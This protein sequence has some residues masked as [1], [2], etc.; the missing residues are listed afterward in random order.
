MT[1]SAVVLAGAA[2]LLLPG[3]SSTRDKAAEV[4]QEG[5]KAFEAK[6]L[7]LT[8]SNAD[9]RVGRPALV[10]DQNGTAVVV[11]LENRTKAT[12]GSVP[13]GVVVQDAAGE[14]IWRNDAAGLQ[15]SLAS[16]GVL[17]AGQSLTWVND[18]VLPPVGTPAK[19]E[20]Q[21]GQA[22]E[23][24]PQVP[25]L[26]AGPPTLEGDPVDG[27]AARGEV[28][29]DSDQ[30]LKD[31]VVTGVGRR[32]SRVVAAGRAVI[33]RLKPRSKG[34]YAIFFIGDPRGTTLD[35]QVAPSGRQQ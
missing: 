18:Q 13:V 32:G 35:V 10:R 6:G 2:L 26:V 33:P 7:R 14:A 1:R 16:A 12:L 15:T 29:N 9:V 31:V 23:R 19:A 22:A 5:S 30:D 8:E 11:E 21:A 4:I 20:V 3:C 24:D 28:T 17:P 25:K 27:V 34:R